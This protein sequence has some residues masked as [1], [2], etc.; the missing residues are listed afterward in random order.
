MKIRNSFVSNSSSTS[1]IVQ[2]EDY[3]KY[4]NVLDLFKISDLY[5][6]YKEVEKEI[7]DLKDMLPYFIETDGF[8]YGSVLPYSAEIEE[9]YEKYPE[10]Y[11]S[12]SYDRDQAFR[13]GIDC[14]LEAFDTDL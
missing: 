4:K 9:I 12:D 13:N 7:D 1:F 14:E 2:A 10:A 3:D 11:I 6:K 5:R 8:L